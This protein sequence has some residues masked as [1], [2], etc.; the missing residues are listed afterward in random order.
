MWVRLQL[1]RSSL[2]I[3]AVYL[4]SALSNNVSV[5]NKLGSSIGLI[6]GRLNLSDSILVLGDFILPLL[7]WDTVPGSHTDVNGRTRTFIHFIPNMNSIT[8]ST[9]GF[10]DS[11]NE[12]DLAQISGVTN[13]NN[14]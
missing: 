5:H 8:S 3:D 9:T 14:R 7:S 12:N 10:E 1:Y 11:V 2:Y 4:P 13:I 6:L